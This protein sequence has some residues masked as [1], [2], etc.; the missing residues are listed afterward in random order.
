MQSS[1]N[2]EKHVEKSNDRIVAKNGIL[3]V[4]AGLAGLS[5]ALTLA[6]RGI[7]CTVIEKQTEIVPSKWA[8]LVYPQ[9]IKIFDELGVLEDIRRLGVPLKPPEMVVDG[10]TL[11]V[12]DSGL[13]VEP[14]VQLSP[15]PRTF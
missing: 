12:A 14:R 5:L 4:G 13:L 8:I 9:G 6:R 7:A 3:I 11:L 10:A 2:Q 1:L 15:E